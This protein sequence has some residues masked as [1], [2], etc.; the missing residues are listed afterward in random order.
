[1]VQWAPGEEVE[2][3]MLWLDLS[4]MASVYDI[5][6]RAARHDHGCLLGDFHRYSDV[7]AIA[8]PRNDGHVRKYILD[9]PN[10]PTWTMMCASGK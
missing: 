6:T 7:R 5:S 4:V 2:C 3:C 9:R 1:M 10:R 8:F